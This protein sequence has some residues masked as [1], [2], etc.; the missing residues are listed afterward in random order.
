MSWSLKFDERIALANGEALRST[1][2]LCRKPHSGGRRTVSPHNTP[3]PATRCLPM[4]VEDP[5]SRCRACGPSQVAPLLSVLA[6]GRAALVSTA[7]SIAA[8]PMAF[9][10]AE[11]A[12]G[13]SD[14]RRLRESQHILALLSG[15]SPNRIMCRSIGPMVLGCNPYPV[16]R[17]R[18][19]GHKHRA[20]AREQIAFLRCNGARTKARP[21]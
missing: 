1:W 8:P 10:L 5:A 14:Q 15:N 2:R 11:C 19:G 9:S 12:T 4:P 7:Q 20:E 16:P 6:W 13:A 3:N 18:G 17:I 21:S